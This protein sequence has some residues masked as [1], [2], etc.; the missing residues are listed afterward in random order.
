MTSIRLSFYPLGDSYLLVGVAALV[1]LGLLAL[2]PP[3][4]KLSAGRRWV[5]SFIRLLVVAA[6]VLAML[7]PTLLYTQSKKQAATLILLADRSRSMS[8]PDEEGKSRFEALRHALDDARVALRN[9]A[10]DFEVKAYTFDARVHPAEIVGGQV[11][12]GDTPD[13]SQTAIGAALEDVLREQAGKRLLGVIILSDGAQRAYPPRDTLPQTA[14]NRLKQLGYPLYAFRFG[15]ARGLGQVQDVAVKEMV[16]SD[17]V[18]VKN[19]LTVAGR[20]RVDGYVN[21]EI[22]VRLLFETSP[23]KMEP[24]AQQLLRASADGELLQV[25]FHFIPQLPGEFKITLEAAEQPGELVT[26]NN[27]MTTFVNVLTGGLKVLYLEGALRVEQRFLRRSLDASQDIRVDFFRLDPKQPEKTRPPDLADQFKP[28]KY[29]VYIIGDLDSTAFQEKEL[30]QLA[31]TVSR[32]AGLLMLGGFHS[33]GPGGYAKTPLADVLPVRMSQLERQPLGE[34]IATDLHLRGPLAMKPTDLALAQSHS[35]VMLAP[36]RKETVRLWSRLPPLDGA[37][38]FREL[39]PAALVLAESGSSQP[40]LAVLSL[41]AGRTMAFAGDSTWRWCMH[42]FGE[43][44]KRFWRQVVLWLARKDES[45]EGNVWVKLSE[46][47][48]SPNQR[49]EFTAG[50]NLATGEPV[51][52][53]AFQGEALL[54]DGSRRS[55]ALVKA[56]EQATGS[57][58]DTR[59]PGDYAIQVSANESGKPLGTSRARFVV[60]EEDLELDNA[61]ADATLLDS[62]AAMTGGKS[63]APEELPKLIERMTQQTEHL[64]VQTE[65]KETF[66]DSWPFFLAVVGLLGIEWYLR[67]RWSLV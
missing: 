19:E 60:V 33:F 48:L 10:R 41:G 58:H 40:L 11:R 47:R 23:D 49:V 14:A 59:T 9:L 51:K 67:K 38:R 18:F 1:L 31:E 8:V 42:G 39:K 64:V 2:G 66:W 20:I 12:I 34:P 50:A 30:R 55:L 17:R 5:L 22:P 52:D 62:L 25:K 65:T 15:Q 36:D 7:R 61:S 21:R 37:N 24:V 27:R 13:G 35:V 32:G 63:L 46:R 56:G 3:R 26:T 54:P 6:I 57:F 43:A 28:G 4:A 16:A 53:A 45:Q 44:H 29:D